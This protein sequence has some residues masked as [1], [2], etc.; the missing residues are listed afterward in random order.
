MY[1]RGNRDIDSGLHLCGKVYFQSNYMK[2]RVRCNS[3]NNLVFQAP[4]TKSC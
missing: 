2:K 1:F 3:L 4:Q